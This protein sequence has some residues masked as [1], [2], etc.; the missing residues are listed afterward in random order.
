MEDKSAFEVGDRVRLKADLPTDV[1]NFIKVG[2]PIG[3]VIK[4]DAE[5]TTVKY[6]FYNVEAATEYFEFVGPKL[7]DPDS[8]EGIAAEAD[9]VRSTVLEIFGE[10][11][12]DPVIKEKDIHG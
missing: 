4:S 7:Y 6:E 10:E 2:A 5:Q 9:V 1:L 8:L 11:D 3:E 12:E